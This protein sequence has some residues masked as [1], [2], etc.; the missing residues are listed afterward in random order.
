M[1]YKPHTDSQKAT[2]QSDNTLWETKI[3][4]SIILKKPTPQKI[5]LSEFSE[6]YLDQIGMAFP[7]HQRQLTITHPQ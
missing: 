5:G 7:S 4:N 2:I 6:D 3:S 1:K